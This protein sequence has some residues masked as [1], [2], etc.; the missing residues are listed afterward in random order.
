VDGC[1]VIELLRGIKVLECTVLPTGDQAGRLLCDLGAESIKI[2]QPGIGDYIRELGGQMAPHQSPTH[3]L[4]NRHKR[5][6]SL[7]LR[8]E[9]G[10]RVF[11][12]ILP[13]IDIFVDGFAGDACRRLGIGYEDQCKVKPDIIYC[14]ASGFGTTGPYG[15]IPVHGYMMGAVAGST[16]LTVREDG[17]VQE[18]V[19]PVDLNFPGYVDGPLMGGLFGAFTAVAALNYRNATGKGVYI[20]ASGTD[21]TLAAQSLDATTV[22]NLARTAQRE[23]L[24][25]TVGS[26]PVDRPKYAFYQTK[27][28]KFVLLATIEHKFWDNFCEAIERPDLRD[29]K[30]LDSPVDFHNE[31]GRRD[32]AFELSPIMATRTLAE[33]IDI[34]RVYDIPLSP[35]NTLEGVL[36]DPHLS[37]REIIHESVHPQAGP[38]TTV[39]WPAPVSGQPFDVQRPAPMLG[40]HTEEILAGLGYSDEDVQ[41]FRRQGIV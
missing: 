12:E 37:A 25:P 2:E 11:Y 7:N 4:V 34:A 23:N 28:G 33:W 26:N 38:F 13:S 6:L 22:W 29:V 24:P 30:Y 3:L 16:R 21:G 31:G 35:A 17:L 20:D 14:Q 15:Q 32:L 36:D 18:V 1:D 9:E 40:Q 10:R 5:S 8:T 39:G 27:D 19:E 41:E